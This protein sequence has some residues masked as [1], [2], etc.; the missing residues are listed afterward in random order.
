MKYIL[1]RIY[2]QFS[3]KFTDEV[4]GQNRSRAAQILPSDPGVSLRSNAWVLQRVPQFLPPTSLKQLV[5][6]RRN[7]DSIY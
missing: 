6:I 1:I 5:K 7:Y 4:S 3:T 2:S